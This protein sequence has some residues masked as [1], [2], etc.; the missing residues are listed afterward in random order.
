M[1]DL[2]T[3]SA[4]PWSDAIK[5]VLAQLRKRGV[6]FSGFNAAIDSDLKLGT[7]GSGPLEIATALTLR[8]LYPFSL[9]ETGATIPPKRNAKNQL[10]PLAGAEK[11]FYARL[12]QAAANMRV[13][14]P[15]SLLG[16]VSS[17]FGK[18]WHVMSVDLRFFTVEHAPMIG[19][20][21]IICDPGLKQPLADVEIAELQSQSQAAAAKL[22]AK[23]LR[24]VELKFLKASQSSLTAREYA[25]A[26][27]MVG[28]TE[29]VV[30]GERALREDDHR[31]FGQY[32]FQSHESSRDVLQNR[33]PELDLLVEMARGHRGCLGARLTDGGFGAA[34]VNLVAYH[35]AENFMEAMARNY[36][37]RTGSK[38][39]PI[40]CQIGDG[41]G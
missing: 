32:M 17:L 26:R 7:G 3:N 37:K 12:C 23:S 6:H 13:G 8:Q 31:Q 28:E 41:A 2:T 24:S 35:Q 19:E 14:P 16:P 4:A 5:N 9:T 20:V 10:P 30:F 39:Q 38:L 1:S 22:G 33:P 27:H 40:L 25:C 18:A 29:R 21:V 15:S 36:E 11:I 34:T